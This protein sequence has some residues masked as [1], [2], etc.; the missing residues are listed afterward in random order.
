MLPDFRIL[1][2]ATTT[3]GIEEL[4][5]THGLSFKKVAI[6]CLLTVLSDCTCETLFQL[7]QF[8]ASPLAKLQWLLPTPTSAAPAH[9]NTHATT[10]EVVKSWAQEGGS[11]L[12]KVCARPILTP[13]VPQEERR[14]PCPA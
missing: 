11:M 3:R 13:A 6:D 2:T 12:N 1:A 5:W 8:E 4:L 7:F 10:S 14:K 9:N